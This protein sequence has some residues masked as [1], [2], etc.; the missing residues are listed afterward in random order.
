YRHVDGERAAVE[1]A[2]LGGLEG[3][4]RRLGGRQ[5]GAGGDEDI[6]R[7]RGGARE[8]DSAGGIGAG[9][10]REDQEGGELLPGRRRGGGAAMVVVDE[11][12]SAG[13]GPDSAGGGP[14]V[15]P[16]LPLDGPF[17]GEGEIAVGPEAGVGAGALA[18]DQQRAGDDR[19]RRRQE[20]RRSL[21]DEE[22]LLARHPAG[23]G[24][25][26]VVDELRVGLGDVGH[27]AASSEKGTTRSTGVGAPRS[28]TVSS[29]RTL[30]RGGW[31][32]GPTVAA[33]TFWIRGSS[34]S[35]CS[36]SE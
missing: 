20:E 2:V 16:G 32:S 22:D 25:Q 4:R 26:Q 18:E 14:A 24:G 27:S 9:A 1:G 34:R 30:S 8:D 13:I 11:E 15:R 6:G 31:C 33:S 29:I 23:E 35:A 19:S 5:A 10:A 12:G 3:H 17:G 21:G 28:W 7:R 36:T